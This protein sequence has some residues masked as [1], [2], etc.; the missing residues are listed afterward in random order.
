MRKITPNGKAVI[1]TEDGAKVLD[2]EV[3]GV[4]NVMSDIYRISF[5]KPEKYLL[6]GGAALEQPPPNKF[7]LTLRAEAVEQML[8]FT[9]TRFFRLMLDLMRQ[10]QFEPIHS[11]NH[12]VETEDFHHDTYRTGVDFSTSVEELD[13]QFY[14]SYNFTPAM[15]AFIE[16][17]YSYDDIRHEV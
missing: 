15:I 6:I 9:R 8:K 14:R 7:R 12:F 16:E 17:K 2:A 4:F 1:Y 13:A 5:D 11:V 10:A 3:I